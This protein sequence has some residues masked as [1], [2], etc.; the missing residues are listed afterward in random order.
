MTVMIAV[1]GVVTISYALLGR[2]MKRIG[3]PVLLLFIGAGIVCASFL[4][5]RGEGP[6]M[7]ETWQIA[8][9]AL[10]LQ[11]FYAGFGLR[12]QRLEKNHPILQR[13]R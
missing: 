13:G 10:V 7:E 6:G 9:V 11:T 4:I 3:L 12:L 8:A 2:V 5:K 1:L